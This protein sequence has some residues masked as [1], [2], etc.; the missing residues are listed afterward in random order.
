[1]DVPKQHI[2][3]AMSHVVPF[4]VAPTTANGLHLLR[5]GL[6]S[7]LVGPSL[8]GQVSRL[9]LAEIAE[10]PVDLLSD[11][12]LNIQVRQD[13]VN[14]LA[15]PLCDPADSEDDKRPTKRSRTRAAID[16]TMKAKTDQVLF[17]VKNRIASRRVQ[18]SLEDAAQLLQ[19]LSQDSASGSSSNSQALAEV[20]NDVGA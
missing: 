9:I 20:V 13:L 19:D 15:A 10:V 16:E 2:L 4:H 18:S 8:A 5:S 17:M 6:C 11:A 1:M 7:K 14:S 3:H 12:E